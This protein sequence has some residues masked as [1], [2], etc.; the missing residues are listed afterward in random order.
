MFSSIYSLQGNTTPSS[1]PRVPLLLLKRQDVVASGIGLQNF[2]SFHRSL[3][4][5]LS[6][7]LVADHENITE[8]TVFSF[9]GSGQ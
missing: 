8:A 3:P 1:S 5:G 2:A 4:W 6:F 7:L 9:L